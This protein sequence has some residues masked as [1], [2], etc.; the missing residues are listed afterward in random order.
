MC[1]KKTFIVEV[2]NGIANEPSMRRKG[3]TAWPLQR[4][5]NHKLALAITWRLMQNIAVVEALA[6][7]AAEWLPHKRQVPS[8]HE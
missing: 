7:K 2:R 3:K 4:K 5:R 6:A 1:P 8:I